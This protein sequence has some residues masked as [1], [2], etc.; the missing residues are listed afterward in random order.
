MN[1]YDIIQE[2]INKY[3][4]SHYLEIG[5]EGGETFRRIQC[6]IKYGVD[7][8][9]SPVPVNDPNKFFHC[10]SD[11]FFQHRPNYENLKLD[12]VFVDGLHQKEQAL[13][14]I[15]NALH[16]LTPE[17]TIV[18]HDCL[19][20]SEA[21]QVH[22][23]Q[24]GVPWMGDVWKAFAELRMTRT[25]LSMSVV[26]TDCGCGII[27]FGKQD[28]FPRIDNLDWTIFQNSRNELLNVISIEQFKGLY[29]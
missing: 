26:D 2:L 27:R 13:R 4:Y 23:V 28:L 15:E 21:E 12:L 11:Q 3:N 6:N 22:E 5:V 7:P 19:P 14:D 20:R 25:D 10:T 17:G 9:G 8:A 1:R 29:L 24:Y 16:Y 18:V